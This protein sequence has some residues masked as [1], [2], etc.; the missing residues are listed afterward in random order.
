MSIADAVKQLS[1]YS[2]IHLNIKYPALSILFPEQIFPNDGMLT[3]IN[4]LAK[5]V[6][7]DDELHNPRNNLKSQSYSSFM[8]DFS[9]EGER[10]PKLLFRVQPLVRNESYAMRRVNLSVLEYGKDII[11]PEHIDAILMKPDL[12][13]EGGLIVISGSTGSGKTTLVYSTIIERLKRYGGYCLAIEDPTEMPSA[14]GPH[15]REGTGKKGFLAQIDASARGGYEYAIMDG[16]RSIP[17]TENRP[18]VFIGEIRDGKTAAEMLR[19]SISGNLVF[20]TVHAENH[21]AM[22]QRIV[23]LAQN[24][25]EPDARGL[26]QRSLVGSINQRMTPDRKVLYSSLNIN[27][28]IRQAIANNNYAEFSSELKQQQQTMPMMTGMNRT[29]APKF[30]IPS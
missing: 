17:I 7:E 12:Q 21:D 6:L 28:K 5:K 29:P 3:T 23:S 8:V 26:L 15:I 13:R 22:C 4:L 30:Q 18:I 14:Y 16:L 9:P 25:G 11:P 2:D 27:Q 19:F 10:G 1:R 20:T 24:G